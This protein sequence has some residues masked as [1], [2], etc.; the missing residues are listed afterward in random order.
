VIGRSY[1]TGR[2]LRDRW[3]EAGWIES[4]PL[5]HNGPSFLWLSPDGIRVAQSPYRSWR[6]NVVTIGHIEAVTDVRLLLEQHLQLGEWTCERALAQGSPWR[7]QPRPHLPDGLLKRGREQIAIEVELTLKSRVRLTAVMTQLAEQH[8][9]VWYFTTP[10]LLPTLARLA[11]DASG[12]NVAVY[13]YPA[14]AGDLLA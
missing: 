14:Q 1:R 2:W 8:D 7:D 6:P 13:P 3:K 11:N 10:P 12:R 4:A 9:Q 5:T